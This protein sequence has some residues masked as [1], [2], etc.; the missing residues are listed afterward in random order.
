[1]QFAMAD[2]TDGIDNSKLLEQSG[3]ACALHNHDGHWQLLK[4]YLRKGRKRDKKIANLTERI[5]FGQKV[6]NGQQN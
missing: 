2:A 5:L 3:D 6:I 1:M 4:N